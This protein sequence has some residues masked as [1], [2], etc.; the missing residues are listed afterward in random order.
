LLAA[1]AAGGFRQLESVQTAAAQ[2]VREAHKKIIAIG[3]AY[4]D[5]ARRH[6]QL[7][8]LMFGVGIADWRAH[9]EVEQA[10]HA[11][12]GPVKQALASFLGADAS[13]DAESVAAWALVHGLSMLLIDGALSSNE[14]SLVEKAISRFVLGLR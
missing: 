12:Y 2:S 14:A 9:P 10:K 13:I 7:Y 3:C 8:R 5:F 6:P 4:V 1:L 11:T